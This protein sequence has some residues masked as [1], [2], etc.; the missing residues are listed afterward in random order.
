MLPTLVRVN[1]IV[2]VTAGVVRIRGEE[3]RRL[4]VGGVV[5]AE[6]VVLVPRTQKEVVGECAQVD[7]HRGRVGEVGSRVEATIEM[8]R[9]EQ[10]AATADGV[11]PVAVDEHV[12]AGGPNVMGGG[13]NPIRLR[14][15]PEARTPSVT[16]LMPYPTA[17]QPHVV[18]RRRGNV[19][20]GL[21][22]CRWLGQV[23]DFAQLSVGPVS[24]GP[25][26]TLL[27]TAPIP[28]YPLTSWRQGAPDAAYPKKI[29][30]LVIPRP[31]TGNPRNVG[32]F[33]SLVRRQ[34]VD[35]RRRRR[36]R[37]DA[38]LGVERY[39]SREGLVD[40]PSREHLHP[41]LGIDRAGL[42]EC[43]FAEAKA[44]AQGH[45]C[46]HRAPFAKITYT[47][48]HSPWKTMGLASQWPCGNSGEHV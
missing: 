13:P 4:I 25:L 2:A 14:G 38:R 1:R 43:G 3:P 21:N 10:Y 47:H 37:Y 44:Q 22:G 35:S 20:A 45:Q 39:R 40:W 11:I 41:I 30:S 34:F 32:S 23:F 9:G 27:G 48:L 26:E 46:A 5:V 42:C 6:V 18:G 17:R 29:A 33:R 15:C 16:V 31:V 28:G 19:G 24:G 12:A 36:W 7:H 8:H